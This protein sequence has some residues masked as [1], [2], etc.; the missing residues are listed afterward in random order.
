MQWSVSLRIALMGVNLVAGTA[1][2]VLQGDAFSVVLFVS[3]AIAGGVLVSLRPRNAVSWLMLAIGWGLC[4]ATLSLHTSAEALRDG[5]ASGLEALVAWGTGWGWTLGLAALLTLCV[6]FPDGRLPRGRWRPPAVAL[7]LFTAL[8]WALTAFAPTISVSPQGSPS[9]VDV[10]NP[11]GILPDLPMWTLRAPGEVVAIVIPLLLAVG[12]ITLIARYRRSS[13]LEKLQ[14]RWL[15]AALALTVVGTVFGLLAVEFLGD[16]A[17]VPVAIA[18]ASIPAAIAIA[19]LRYRL[20]DIDLV[21]NRTVVYGGATMLLAAAFGL[22]NLAAQRLITMATGGPSDLATAGLAVAAAIAFAPISRRI[23][24]IADRLLPPRAWL[25]LLFTDI[26]GSTQKAVEL[27]DR[28]WRE[29]L[30]RYRSLVRRDLARFGGHEVDTAGDGFFATF[31]R[32]TAAVECALQLRSEVRALG[33]D[34][35]IGLHYGE[36]EMR[37]EKVTGIAVHAAARVMSEAGPGELLV[38]EALRKA[39]AGGSFAATDRGRHELKGVPGEWTLY[40]IEATTV[41]G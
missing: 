23:R 19:V 39:I 30:E 13:G 29:L 38:S 40:A 15:V 33:L 5:T 26:V 28:R 9:E 41:N 20:Y 22:A 8:F 32:A 35:R 12:A 16:V 27:G 24:P 1:L 18:Y 14:L 25:T 10:R 11:F 2:A 4:L 36:C 37:G 17:W 6:V 31:E 21:I 34:L 7:V 3:Y